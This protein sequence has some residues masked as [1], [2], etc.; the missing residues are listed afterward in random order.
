ME[1]IWDLVVEIWEINH[2]VAIVLVGIVVLPVLSFLF[3]LSGIFF[4]KPDQSKK[5]PTPEEKEYTLRY[6]LEQEEKARRKKEQRDEFLNETMRKSILERELDEWR[7][8]AVCAFCDHYRERSPHNFDFGYCWYKNC[9][10]DPDFMYTIRTCKYYANKDTDP[11]NQPP[12]YPW[13]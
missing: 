3:E 2:L 11:R 1:W 6:Q 7:R 5:E 9:D 4:A 8:S 12:P 13:N 10:I